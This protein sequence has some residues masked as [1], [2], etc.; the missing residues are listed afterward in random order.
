MLARCSIL[1]ASALALVGCA[2]PVSPTVVGADG[3]HPAPQNVRRLAAEHVRTVLMEP[4]TIRDA[5]ISAM[6]YGGP[7]LFPGWVVCVAAQGRGRQDP[8][9]ASHTLYLVFRGDTVVQSAHDTLGTFCSG[10]KFEA[11]PEVAV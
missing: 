3:R 1:L 4:A 8:A 9:I 6:W 11:F 10:V 2:G 7:P 5:R